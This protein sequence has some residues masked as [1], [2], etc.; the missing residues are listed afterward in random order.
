MSQSRPALGVAAFVLIVGALGLYTTLNWNA[1]THE[2]YI[3]SPAGASVTV[4]GDLLDASTRRP[5]PRQDVLVHTVLLEPGRH[6]IGAALETVEISDSVV[7]PEQRRPEQQW[8]VIRAV[9]DELWLE[10]RWR[11]P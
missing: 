8:V 10:V 7:V 1:G 2:I 9:R 3:Q 6:L 11:S 4:D 5:D